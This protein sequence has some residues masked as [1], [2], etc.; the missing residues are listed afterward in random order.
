M[1]W[2]SSEHADLRVVRFLTQQFKALKVNIPL[3]MAAAAALSLPSLRSHEVSYPPQSIVYE[4]ITK[5]SLGSREQ[6]LP[7]GG[8]C[9][10]EF[11]NIL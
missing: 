8:R 11:E 5:V 3:S 2:A 10:N 1:S 4:R 6:D 7:L 9:V